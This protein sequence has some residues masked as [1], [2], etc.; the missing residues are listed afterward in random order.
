MALVQPGVALARHEPAPHPPRLLDRVRDAIRT[1][2]YSPRTE[3]A[4]CAWI[5]RFI[6]FH[7]RRHPRDLGPTDVEAF[8]THLATDQHVSASTQN[9]ALAAILFLYTHVLALPLAQHVDF[10]RAKRPERLPAVLTPTEVS[11][12][13]DRMTGVP[14]L[15]ASLLYGAGFRLLECA[16]LRVKDLDLERREIVVRDGK[17]RKDRITMLPL[18]LVPELRDHLTA[19]PRPALRRSRGRRRLGGAPRCPGPEVSECRPGVALAMGLPGHATLPRPGD[20]PASQASSARD[21]A[22]ARCPRGGSRR[23]SIEARELPH[24]VSLLRHAPPGS[25]LRHPHD[26]GAPRPPRR[27]HDNDLHPR[28]EPRRPGSP[29]PPRRPFRSAAVGRPIDVRPK[30]P[31]RVTQARRA[32]PGRAVR[33]ALHRRPPAPWKGCD[34]RRC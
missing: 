31:R 14:R 4:Y 26:P 33:R 32:A 12:L 20:R 2:R 3:E 25:R 5:R 15:M 34:R 24:P 27:E 17:G 6:L 28:P 8:L 1:R 22:P 30:P 18:R 13:L 19:T 21:G 29:E 10:T 11:A 23:G 9:Q 7:G 16:E